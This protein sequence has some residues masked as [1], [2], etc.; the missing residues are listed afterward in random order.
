M[1]GYY[2][3][4]RCDLSLKIIGSILEKATE[5]LKQKRIEGS[6]NF[7][8]YSSAKLMSIFYS[9]SEEMTSI[10]TKYDLHLDNLIFLD[11]GC[12]IGNVLIPAM[13]TGLFSKCVGLEISSEVIKA[14]KKNYLPS[15]GNTFKKNIHIKQTDILKYKKYGNYDVIYYFCPFHDYK[16]EITFEERIEEQAKV[17]A[18]LIPILKASRMIEED[19][20]FKRHILHSSSQSVYIKVCQ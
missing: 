9:L 12:G 3:K 19:R 15:F 6:Y 16:L 20:R 1:E 13:A 14:A 11:A 10:H 8:P 2:Y 5:S 4:G 18:I 7:I 17:G